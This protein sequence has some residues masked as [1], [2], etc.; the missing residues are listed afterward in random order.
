MQG[1][2]AAQAA[3][4]TQPELQ[5]L[6]EELEIHQIELELQNEHLNQARSQL[7]AALSQSSELYD[8]SPVGS[9]SLDGSGSITKLNLSAARLLGAERTRVLGSKLALYLSEADRPVFN[10]LM[11]RASDS[12]D[13][14]GA[15]V[16]LMSM[17]LLVQ[18]VKERGPR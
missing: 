1:L 13:V 3:E 16:T 4:L 15:E 9:L 2:G 7:E 5:Q 8:F 17:E 12:G 18:Y 14:Q 11:Q 6:L 10:A